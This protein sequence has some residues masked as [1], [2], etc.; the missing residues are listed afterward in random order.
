M[1]AFYLRPAHLRDDRFV[2]D[3]VDEPIEMPWRDTVLRLAP[4]RTPQALNMLR[5][6]RSGWFIGTRKHTATGRVTTFVL[7][8][9]GKA[10]SIADVLRRQPMFGD[11]VQEVFY[12][13]RVE[14]DA[15]VQ[16]AV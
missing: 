16:E 12:I 11:E 14:W 4:S 6:A 5:I 7:D 9:A 3:H 15:Q 13:D 1:T 2:V 8:A 10:S